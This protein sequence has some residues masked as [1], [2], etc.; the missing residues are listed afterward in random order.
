MKSYKSLL[1]AAVLAAMV[2]TTAFAATASTPVVTDNPPAT[3][4]ATTTTA[5]A[6]PATG[7][8]DISGYW[9][10]DAVQYFYDNHYVSGV[11]GNFYP[12]KSISRE[13][14]ASIIHNIIGGEVSTMNDNFTDMGGRWSSAAVNDLV[15]KK[16]MS[17]Y[18]DRTFRPEQ[19][20]TR[21]EFAN[22]AYNYM[23]YK[24]VGNN[25]IASTTYNDDAQIAD[26]AKKAVNVLSGEG[27]MTGS[28]NYFHPQEPVTRGE[29]VNVLYRIITGTQVKTDG[30][31]KMENLVFNDISDVY[32]SV[33]KF[34]GDGIMYWQGDKLHVGCKNDEMRQK[35]LEAVSNDTNIPANTVL[36]QH[37]KYSFNDYKKLMEKAE[38]TYRATE[39]TDA[40]VSTD[41]DYLNEK[42][43][44][45][46]SSITKETQENIIKKCGSDVKIVIQ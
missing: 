11:N 43:I 29:A 42:V 19:L 35:L 31:E 6:T 30:S 34:A 36:V 25:T 20:V 7:L 21:Q 26:W 38:S 13:G 14:V 4:T 28:Y 18:P 27:Y 32:G 16:I 41:V 10:K 3:A 8:N 12:N 23:I 39:P 15:D 22:I 24:G 9:G 1:T 40:T 33:K 17:G 45:T 5:P 46:C 37:A 44:L 2:S